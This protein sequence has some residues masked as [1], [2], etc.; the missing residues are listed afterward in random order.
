MSIVSTKQVAKDWALQTSGGGN[1]H[2]T[3]N[4]KVIRLLAHVQAE[5][6]ASATTLHHHIDNGVSASA[7]A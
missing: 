3:N 7:T 1:T 4:E 5:S 2:S 6:C